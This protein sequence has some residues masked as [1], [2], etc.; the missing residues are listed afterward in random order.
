MDYGR[1]CYDR[2]RSGDDSA[3]V[4][5]MDMFADGL[6][7]YLNSIVHD[8]S[9]AEELTEEAFFR[10]SVNKPPFFARS[11]FKTWLY[12]IGRNAAMDWLRRN[13]RFSGTPVE[14]YRTLS[15]ETDL[16]QSYI[17][18]EQM[19]LLHRAIEKLPDDYRQVL[20][21]FYFENFD[22]AQTARIMDRSAK[23]VS[24]LLFRAKASLRKQ[25][26]KEGFSYEVT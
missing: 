14:D 10:I 15:D 2:Y 22:T 25:L 5:L 21:L 23:Q 3:L 1:Q 4:E 24:N 11:A 6:T 17:R 8:I 12:A 20:H 19:I 7:L 18:K 9:L 13:S 16:E 26:E